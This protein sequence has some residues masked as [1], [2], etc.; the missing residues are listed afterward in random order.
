MKHVT[1]RVE[2]QFAMS[3]MMHYVHEL[4]ADESDGDE[5]YAFKGVAMRSD[6]LISNAG[7]QIEATIEDFD[8]PGFTNI[9]LTAPHDSN[10]APTFPNWIY[11]FDL[12]G[13]DMSSAVFSV[14]LYVVEKDS[15]QVGPSFIEYHNKFRSILRQAIQKGDDSILGNNKLQ[16]GIVDPYLGKL[17]LTE[18]LRKID[19]Q[20]L[21]SLT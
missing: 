14:H 17:I 1:V 18:G 7:G 15:Y 3:L 5:V 4:K 8:L 19:Q 16:A 11:Q 12:K 13:K 6:K 21:S 9:D 2:R 20:A 10:V